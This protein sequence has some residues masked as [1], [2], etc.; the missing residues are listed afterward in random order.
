MLEKLNQD[1]SKRAWQD[2]LYIIQREAIRQHF[3]AQEIQLALANMQG[4]FIDAIANYISNHKTGLVKVK[5]IDGAFN[6][7]ILDSIELPQFGIRN[8][9]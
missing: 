7:E 4:T 3:T 2:V 9:S 6:V 8:S 1:V 5:E